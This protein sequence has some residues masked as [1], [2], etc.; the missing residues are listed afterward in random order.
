MFLDF[1]TNIAG[2]YFLAGI[3]NGDEVKQIV[4]N[5]KL[6]G[7]ANYRKMEIASPISFT[8]KFLQDVSEMGDTVIGYSTAEKNYI[9]KLLG[10][11]GCQFHNL[12]YLNIRQ[13]AVK[14]VNEYQ[15]AKFEALA[16]LV[17]TARDYEKKRHKKSLA[18]IARLIDYPAPKDYAIGKTTKRINEVIAALEL[19]QQNYQNLTSVQKAKATRVL[20]HN[21]FD[22]DAM[23]MLYKRI[24]NDDARLL[25]SS[26]IPLFDN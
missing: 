9:N 12:K 16:P 3:S 4:L 26:I 22:V 5:E 7:L 23:V 24:Q 13:A 15:R 1:E 19:R 20:K 25:S 11:Q 8:K 18:S 17:I 21:F 6:R 14:W 10:E 2:D